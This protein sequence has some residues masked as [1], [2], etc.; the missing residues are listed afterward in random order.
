MKNPFAQ[1]IRKRHFSKQHWRSDV[2][3][4]RSP[5]IQRNR[6]RKCATSIVERAT[7]WCARSIP[8]FRDE[9]VTVYAM[10]EAPDK[11]ETH[12]MEEVNHSCAPILT[13]GVLFRT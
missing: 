9:E 5:V 12:G 11:G 7:Y 2:F 4:S 10:N 3:G 8:R 1:S 6:R 13:R